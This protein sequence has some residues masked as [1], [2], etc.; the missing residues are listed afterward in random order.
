[1]KLNFKNNG[2]KVRYS[3]LRTFY[4]Q[5]YK[6]YCA[7][8]Y[9]DDRRIFINMYRMI[10]RMLLVVDK[11]YGQSCSL[12]VAFDRQFENMTN[13]LNEIKERFEKFEKENMTQAH[14]TIKV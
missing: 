1:M 13:E 3:Y 12:N 7:G 14:D 8:H 11:V 2:V 10:I 9:Y 6:K 5:T 4:E